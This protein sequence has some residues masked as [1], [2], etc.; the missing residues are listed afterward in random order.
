MTWALVWSGNNILMDDASTKEYEVN[1]SDIN[2]HAKMD[3][4][5][6]YLDCS[7]KVRVYIILADGHR[8]GDRQPLCMTVF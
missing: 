5:R 1:F 2:M 7:Q 4:M 3:C 8:G 6:S